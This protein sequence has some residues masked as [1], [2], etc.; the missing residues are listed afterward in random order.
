MR[1]G[2]S[3]Q[4]GHADTSRSPHCVDQP[5]QPL[6]RGQREPPER[7]AVEVDARARRRARSARGS[8]PADRRRRAPRRARGRSRHHSITVVHPASRRATRSPPPTS[9]S[10]GRGG[11]SGPRP[12]RSRARS[13]RPRPRGRRRSARLIAGRDGVVALAVDEQ[14]RHAEREPRG[15]RGGGVA[16]RALLR[17]AAQQPRTTPLESRSRHASWRS[18]TPAW[19]TAPV[20]GTRAPSCARRPRREVAAGGVA[21]RDDA[22]EV[23][24]RRGRRRRG[25]SRRAGEIG[26]VVDPRRHVLERGRPAAAVAAARAG[27]TRGSTPPTRARPGPRTAGASACART[28]PSRSRRAAPRRRGTARRRPA[29]TARRSASAP[30]RSGAAPSRLR[31]SRPATAP[32][33]PAA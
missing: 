24:R 26:Q 10:P 13:R 23:Q 11:R 1:T 9:G 32:P 2:A 30:G 12:P 18:S 14:Q 3:I 25:R 16:L 7:V 15:R 6:A 31:P 29:G 22:R 28:A 17:R 33:R 21:D 27:G 5:V 20:T 19:E 4:S 8:P